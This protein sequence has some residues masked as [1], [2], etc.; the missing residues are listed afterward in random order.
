MKVRNLWSCAVRRSR[1]VKSGWR[2]FTKPGM[3]SNPLCD[4]GLA[5][6]LALGFSL[7]AVVLGELAIP[8]WV[9]PWYP[10]FSDV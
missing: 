6:S 2:P 5:R 1:M 8:R 10:V 4:T 7:L 3:G 9:S